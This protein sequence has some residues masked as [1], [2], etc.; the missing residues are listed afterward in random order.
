MN[1]FVYIDRTRCHHWHRIIIQR[2]Q[3]KHTGGCGLTGEKFS[4]TN[5]YGGNPFLEN[6]M[7]A[8]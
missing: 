4:K 1:L 3:N 6:D 5:S 8:S 7:Q 2:G